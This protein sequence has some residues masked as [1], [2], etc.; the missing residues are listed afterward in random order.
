MKAELISI[1][2]DLS[3]FEGRL[4]YIRCAQQLLNV[5]V[6]LK[7]VNNLINVKV[8][9][10]VT[11]LSDS[12]KSVS[13][14]TVRGWLAILAKNGAIKYKYSGKIIINPNYVFYGTAENF[15]ST[16]KV[17][18]EFKSDVAEIEIKKAL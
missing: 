16:V 15:Y 17:W 14:R 18:E 13:A 9:E 4:S 7:D 1:N 3:I 8:K 6:Y 11:V 5:L 12:N 10:L 2:C